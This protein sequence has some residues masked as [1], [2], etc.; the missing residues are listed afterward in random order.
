MGT[1]P[2][3]ALSSL[4]PIGTTTRMD[5]SS[6]TLSVHGSQELMLQLVHSTR[7]TIGFSIVE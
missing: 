5:S 7:Q 4:A 1:V 3:D 6:V 2:G